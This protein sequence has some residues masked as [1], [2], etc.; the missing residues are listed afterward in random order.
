MGNQFKPAGRAPPG[1]LLFVQA[2]TK[3]KQKTPSP[4]GGMRSRGFGAL[5]NRFRRPTPPGLRGYNRGSDRGSLAACSFATLL[6]AVRGSGCVEAFKTKQRRSS[7]RI[8][9]CGNNHHPAQMEPTKTRRPYITRGVRTLRPLR[10]H[11]GGS[12][13][14]FGYFSGPNQ[15]SDSS[16]GDEDP[17]L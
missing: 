7:L 12:P 4:A 3:S 11:A 10:P 17:R 8:A 9:A 14:S 13:G 6:C 1:A 5:R 16:G 15:K 2:A